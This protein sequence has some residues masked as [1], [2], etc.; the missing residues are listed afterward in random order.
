MSHELKKLAEKRDA[1]LLAEIGAWLHMLWKYDWRFIQWHCGSAP[2]YDCEKLLND[3]RSQSPGLFSFLDAPDP[4]TLNSL[5]ALS[6]VIPIPQS[7]GFKHFLGCPQQADKAIQNEDHLS[8]LLNDAHGRGSG[9]EKGLPYNTLTNQELS[10]SSS[11]DSYIYANT[12]FGFQQKLTSSCYKSDKLRRALNRWIEHHLINAFPVQN[13]ERWKR[14]LKRFHKILT[15]CFP[16]VLAETRKPANDV[17]LHDQTQAAVAFFKAALAERV[18]HGAWK[19]LKDAQGKPQYTWRVLVCR[20]DTFDY[21]SKAITLPDL[22][23]RRESIKSAH[24]RVH[25]LL[26]IDYPLGAEIYRDQST[27]A[28]LVPGE[29]AILDWRDENGSALKKRIQQIYREETAG[30]MTLQLRDALLDDPSRSVYTFGNMLN[31]APPHN[32]P[33]SV[34]VTASWHGKTQVEICTCCRLRPQR[35]SK[36]RNIC[37]VCLTKRVSRSKTW[38]ASGLDTTV[39]LDEAADKNGR[40]VLLACQ[41]DLRYWLN[42]ILWNSVHSILQEPYKDLVQHSRQSF[43]KTK[44]GN[45]KPFQ[46]ALGKLIG[47]TIVS[48]YKNR[49]EA[50]FDEVL[51]PDWKDIIPQADQQTKAAITATHLLRQQPSFPRIRRAWETTL[52]FFRDIQDKIEQGG[53]VPRIPNRLILTGKFST[54]NIWKYYA[55]DTVIKGIETSFVWDADKER[56]IS[57]DNLEYLAK[58]LGFRPREN[59]SPEEEAEGRLSYLSRMIAEQSRDRGLEFYERNRPSQAEEEGSRFRLRDVQIEVERHDY[60]PTVSILTEPQLFMMLVPATHFMDIACHIQNEYERQFSKVRN[61]LPL[62]LSLISFPRRTPLYAAMDAAQRMLKR[63][64]GEQQ[65][66]RIVKKRR[67]ET[68]GETMLRLKQT[69]TGVVMPDITVKHDDDYHYPYF[70]TK[71]FDVDHGSKYAFK[72]P[73]PHAPNTFE[74]LEHISK[75]QEDM[76]VYY[77]PSTFDFELL[78]TT[79][80]RFEIQYDDKGRRG[81]GTTTRRPYFFEQIAECR[82]IWELLAG[83]HGK[84]LTTSQ[85][86]ALSMLIEERRRSWKCQPDEP[87]FQQ[88]VVDSLRNIGAGWWNALEKTEQ[89]LVQQA[90]QSG[91]LADVLEIY[92]EIL[93]QKPEQDT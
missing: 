51:W 85:I 82:R 28:F 83:K 36:G 3:L 78:D 92:M 53:L 90:A 61:R 42:G 34:E 9:I 23:G 50:F 35:S 73:L 88:F 77:T 69:D 81:K 91:M 80:R 86:K 5:H 15:L 59:A 10:D 12:A 1:I 47:K 67:S 40:L 65:T 63:K 22:L 62:H 71:G 70:F 57:A 74:T 49:F 43:G 16:E 26:E 7:F 27:L 93:K 2:K 6:S 48:N 46:S 30:E 52:Q 21:L 72:A 29:G 19:D 13:V 4:Q 55:Y 33:D 45:Y 58:Q 24:A 17:T 84:G 18:A 68:S 8:A 44:K 38:C 32:I 66:W 11:S 87:V 76:E 54:T 41:F 56:L 25:T 31:A 39:W 89:Q 20:T 75:L 60:T 64:S 14:I 37:D 79:G